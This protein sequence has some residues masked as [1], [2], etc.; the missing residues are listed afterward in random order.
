MGCG[1]VC[2]VPEERAD[3][4]AQLLAAHHEGARRIGTATDRAGRVDVPGL[5]LSYPSRT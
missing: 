5:G 2:V 3:E 1:M 4:A